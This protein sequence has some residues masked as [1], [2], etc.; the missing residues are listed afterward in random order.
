M[1]K[2][3]ER[4][5]IRIFCTLGLFLGSLFF[6]LNQANTYATF[7]KRD[8]F[9]LNPVGV[10]ES[11]TSII[12]DKIKINNNL[13]SYRAETETKLDFDRYSFFN[14]NSKYFGDPN[15]DENKLRLKMSQSIVAKDRF[16]KFKHNIMKS[17]ENSRYRDYLDK[18]SF[19]FNLEK[20][21]ETL[22]SLIFFSLKDGADPRSIIPQSITE[23]IANQLP[24]GLLDERGPFHI[25]EK[26]AKDFFYSVKKRCSLE[27]KEIIGEIFEKEKLMNL[28]YSWI[29]YSNFMS[30]QLA[31]QDS[32]QI[33]LR[34]YNGGSR[35]K[36]N[37]YDKLIEKMIKQTHFYEAYSLVYPRQWGIEYISIMIPEFKFEKKIDVENSF[38]L[39]DNPLGINKDS[40]SPWALKEPNKSVLKTLA[41][42]NF[43]S[44]N[45]LVVYPKKAEEF[46]KIYLRAKKLVDL[47]LFKI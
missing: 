10:S 47:T 28:K 4:N 46:T 5:L 13:F 8:Y 44:A 33:G 25:R 21:E 43:L 12:L 40:D 1:K 15:L 31:K 17:P 35:I 36:G 3:L 6:N 7:P 38:W 16:N 29:F 2:T 20:L 37:T 26:T 32:V 27:E 23:S 22:D 39:T 30:D 11:R 18:N 24:Y 19:E 14:V 41:Q 9:I 45:D 42:I 34:R